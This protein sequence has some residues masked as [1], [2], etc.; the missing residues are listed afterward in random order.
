M[1]LTKLAFLALIFPVS[2][3][4]GHII[5]SA[6]VIGVGNTYNGSADFTIKLKDAVGPCSTA[7]Y[8]TFPE[9]KK[10]SD[11]SYQQAFSI[12]LSALATGQNVR[13]L[14]FDND[15]CNEASFILIGQG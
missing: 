13:I 14:N 7:G 4:S 3:M 5:T 15:N 1:K 8:I 10:I 9:S 12:A 2:A 11:A 6:K